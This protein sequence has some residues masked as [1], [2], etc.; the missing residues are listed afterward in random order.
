MSQVVVV[1]LRYKQWL[2][3]GMPAAQA[4][5]ERAAAHAA[6][7]AFLQARSDAAAALQL[8]RAPDTAEHKV[9]MPCTK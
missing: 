2:V 7:K 5:S 6:A 1:L 4:Y 8:L 9:R 3:H